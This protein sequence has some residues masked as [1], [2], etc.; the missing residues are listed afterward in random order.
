MTGYSRFVAI[1]NTKW[2][3]R[4]NFMRWER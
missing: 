1:G 4:A 3:G 2:R